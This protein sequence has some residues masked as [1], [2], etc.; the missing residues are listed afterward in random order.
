MNRLYV[1]FAVAASV[2]VAGCNGGT[3]SPPPGPG[4]GPGV[5]PV[6]TTLGT[7]QT[8]GSTVDPVN[9]DQ[10]PYGLAIAPVTAGAQTA[11]DLIVCNFSD[12]ANVEGA[13]SSI[14]LLHP[15]VG[16]KPT[17]LIAHAALRGCA[18]LVDGPTGAPWVAAYSANDNP[19]VS[20]TG[21]LVSTLSNPVWNGP[22]GQTFSGR[23]GPFG[24]S[25][26]Y[27]SNAGDGSIV[28]INVTG[29]GFTFDKI[30]TGFSVNHGQPGNILAPAGLT[31]QPATDTLYIVDSNVNRVVAL[32][33]VTN[34]PAG[35]VTV[36]GA[37]FGGG[38]AGSA[39][40][41]FAGAPLNAPISSAL[42]PNGNL[43]VGNTGDNNLFEITPQ[44]QIV[45]TKLADS[46]PAGA[47]FG[48]VATGTSNADT[49]VYYNDDNDSTVKVLSH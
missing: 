46:G 8:I 27:A 22:W 32:T 18:A 40:V 25:A 45:G 15:V 34:I 1:S 26:F 2:A 10:N 14:E 35:G 17:R 47:L 48:I 9:G 5:S 49:K 21:A 3:S 23:S 41:V 43:V 37:T 4:P 7:M 6:L 28:R 33:G 19:I 42:L 38:S 36:T 39:R 29:G 30:A 44:G 13:G 16:A 11:G 24:T 12:G 31:Y 20:P